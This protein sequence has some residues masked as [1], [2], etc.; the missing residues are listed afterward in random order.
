MASIKDTAATSA[1][2]EE[3]YINDL[4]D[5][6]L[7][8]QN[9]VLQES[10]AGSQGI[11]DQ[12][13]QGLQDLTDAYVDRTNVEAQKAKDLYGTGGV[14]A[15]AQAQV[16]LTQEN[17]QRK[18]V[19]QLRQAQSDADAEFQRQRK[20]MASQYEAAIKQAQAD[21][22]ME[23]AQAIYEAA[24][25][26]DAQLLELQK[27]GAQLML[28]KGDK[29]GIEAIANG[30]TM[31]RDTTGETW[32]EV[33]QNEEELNAIYDAQLE[34][35]LAQLRSEYETGA[36]DLEAKRQEKEKQTDERLTQTYVDAIRGAKNAAEVQGAYGQGSGTAAQGRLSRDAELQ[37]TLTDIRRGQVGSEGAAGVQALDLVRGYGKSKFDAQD[38]N[39]KARADALLDAAENEEQILLG[40]QQFVGEALAQKGDYSILGKL[41]GLTEDQIKKLKK[42]SGGGSS[43]GS[44]GYTLNDALENYYGGEYNIGKNQVMTEKE[45]VDLYGRLD[46]A[47][48]QEAVAKED[49]AIKAAIVAGNKAQARENAK[50]KK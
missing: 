3:K 39:D 13:Q 42:K 33:R 40:N 21:N 20:L 28:K 44:G 19:Q 46:N 48:K 23:R 32:D 17:T 26:E 30:E 2:N 12:E 31:A 16:G 18:N 45:V 7:K 34:S 41:Y 11:L 5:T 24:K 25:A 10:Y 1:L 6:G 50:K 8:N 35:Q 37:E 36:S 47:A 9:K 4:Y 43:G 15:G 14:S 29:T 49:A 27:Q 38:K 22:D